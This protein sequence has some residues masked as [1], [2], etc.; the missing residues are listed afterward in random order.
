MI[1]E[2]RPYPGMDEWGNREGGR[3]RIYNPCEEKP[4]PPEAPD[5]ETDEDRQYGAPP[6]NFQVRQP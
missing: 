3:I 2:N 1:D 6:S 4:C 5:I